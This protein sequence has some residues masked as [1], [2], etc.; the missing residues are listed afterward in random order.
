MQI[1]GGDRRRCIVPNLWPKAGEKD[2]RPVFKSYGGRVGH[3]P[4][5][6][7]SPTQRDQ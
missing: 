4:I 6:L 2:G 3:A 7:N 5:V 1:R